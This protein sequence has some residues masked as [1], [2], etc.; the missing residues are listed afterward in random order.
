MTIDTNH[1]VVPKK[2]QRKLME[3]AHLSHLGQI[4]TYKSLL[5][6]YYWPQLMCDATAICKNCEDFACFN[7]KPP[8]DSGVIPE[9]TVED[10]M[11][12][13]EIGMDLMKHQ[14]KVFLVIADRATGYS[15]CKALGKLTSSKEVAAITRKIFLKV[16][17]LQSKS[18]WWTQVQGSLQ[19][20][21]GGV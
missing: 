12:M 6:W 14:G 1:L 2:Y 20:N 11:P 7:P 5:S 8:K 15:W 16:G 17:I 19:G 10:L 21:A 9:Y 13:D 18:Q 4:R 3:I